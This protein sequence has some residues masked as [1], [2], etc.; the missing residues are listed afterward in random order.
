MSADLCCLVV[1]VVFHRGASMAA[2]SES[3]SALSWEH[4]L[5]VD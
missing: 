1:A 5:P 3:L 4:Q 2:V